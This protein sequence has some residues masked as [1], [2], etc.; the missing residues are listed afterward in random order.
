MYVTCLYD[1]YN[2][3]EKMAEYIKLFTPLVESGLVIHLY[4]SSELAHHFKDYPSN[5]KVFVVPLKYLELYNLCMKEK[6]ELPNERNPDKDTREYLSLMNTKVELLIRSSEVC[7]DETIIW[8][9]FA[10]LKLFSNS[11]KCIEKF[12]QFDTLFFDKVNIPGCWYKGEAL[13]LNAIH[14]RFCG[15]FVV[16]PRSLMKRFYNDCK[17]TLHIFYNKELK[18]TWEVNVWNHIEYYRGK[19]YV[20]WYYALHN[21]SMINNLLENI[22]PRTN[23]KFEV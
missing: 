16:V 10:I 7:E 21:D 2:K 6:T 11:Q 19:D 1:I 23:K 12:K 22:D 5:I 17:D 18:V 9:D 14:W 8:I 3:P 20:K 4:T 13:Y 15:S